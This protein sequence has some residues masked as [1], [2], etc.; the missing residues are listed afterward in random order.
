MIRAALF[1]LLP[2]VADAQ[3]PR[4][5]LLDAAPTLALSPG[6]W[7]ERTVEVD[8]P[9]GSTCQLLARIEAEP[10]ATVGIRLQ[11]ASST[12]C[13]SA[14]PCVVALALPAGRSL[15]PVV[16]AADAPALAPAGMHPFY[17]QLWVTADPAPGAT[18]PFS[19]PLPG[20]THPLIP[21]SR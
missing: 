13:Q 19:R 7:A 14:A 18:R 2:L 5:V 21:L 4:A 15:V 10:T 16:L 8:C 3:A 12:P 20:I 17:L 9:E 1:F 6:E 11:S